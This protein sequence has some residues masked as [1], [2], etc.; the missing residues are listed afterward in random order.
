M[1]GG[2]GTA[3]DCPLQGRLLTPPN[4]A[5]EMRTGGSLGTVLGKPLGGEQKG[6]PPGRSKLF[7]LM[8][9]HSLRY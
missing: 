3:L 8:P 2:L 6:F 1:E 5:L 9:L 4:G 7:L